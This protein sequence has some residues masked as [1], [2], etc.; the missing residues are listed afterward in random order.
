PTRKKAVKKETEKPVPEVQASAKAEP[1]PES[2]QSIENQ[3]CPLCGKGYIIK[4][5]TAYGCSRWRE[6]C[7]YRKPL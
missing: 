6:G 4:G 3:P 7:N 1:S 2:R 5:K